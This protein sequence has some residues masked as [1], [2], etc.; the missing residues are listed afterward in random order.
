MIQKIYDLMLG[1]SMLV[2]IVVL[3]WYI[4]G[5]SPTT[6]QLIVPLFTALFMHILSQNN[7]NMRMIYNTREY[8]LKGFSR[9]NVSLA[10]IEN[11]LND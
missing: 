9:V 11:K 4:F 2:A 3:L 7:K 5:D 10:R 1:I 8:M 6:V